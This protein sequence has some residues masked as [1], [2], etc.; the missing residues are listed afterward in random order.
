MQENELLLNEGVFHQ[1][2]FNSKINYI[3]YVYPLV[4]S[5][6]ARIVFSF[7]KYSDLNLRINYKFQGREG[8]QGIISTHHRK[9]EIEIGEIE[10]DRFQVAG[11]LVDAIVEGEK[12]WQI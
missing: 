6:P 10:A 7:N 8:S 1:M 9:I 12:K 11:V 4:Y 5:T 2:A 3:S